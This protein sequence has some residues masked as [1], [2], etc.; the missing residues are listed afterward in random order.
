MT[1]VLKIPENKLKKRIRISVM[2]LPLNIIMFL[3]IFLLQIYLYVC[4][5]IS[6]KIP[7]FSLLSFP[8]FLS[9]SEHFESM[10]FNRA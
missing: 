2:S 7:Y 8:N 5:I 10:A 1:E 6:F 3:L 4:Y 9:Y